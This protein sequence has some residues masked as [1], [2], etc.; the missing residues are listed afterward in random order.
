VIESPFEKPDQVEKVGDWYKSTGVAAYTFLKSG[1]PRNFELV[2]SAPGKNFFGKQRKVEWVLGYVSEQQKLAYEFDGKKLTRKAI[3]GD[4]PETSSVTC[5]PEGTAFQFIIS[6]AA[7]R[8]EVQSPSCE[9]ADT[10][11]SPQGDLTKGK[12]G[13]KS[14]PEFVIR[15]LQ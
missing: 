7:N 4:K 1:A 15:P 11:E 9:H 10:Y 12:I 14:N 3:F 8:V 13:I 6:V 5:K 2:F